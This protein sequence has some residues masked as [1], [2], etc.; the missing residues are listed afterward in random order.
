MA[1]HEA[2][3]VTIGRQRSP[4][5]ATGTSMVPYLRAANVKDGRLA[6]AD[7][8]EMNFTESEQATYDLH[9]GDVLVTE[10]CGSIRKIGASARWDGQIDGPVCFQNT[11]LR[12][13]AI[14]GLTLPGF[15]EQWA[16]WAHRSGLWATTASGTNIFHIGVQRAREVPIPVP[17]ID[18][19]RRIVDLVSGIERAIAGADE[20][21]T[22][23]AS[24]NE[25]IL[26]DWV[27]SWT[28]PTACLGDIATAGSGPSWK[29]ADETRTPVSGATRVLGITNTA[30]NAELDL[31][32]EKYV[33]G[34][35]ASTKKLSD[36]SVLMIRTNGNRSRIG[37]VYRVPAGA[38]GCAFSAFQIGLHFESPTD[39][40]FAFWMLAETEV[41][42]RVS[43]A[44]SGTTGLGNVGVRWLKQFK[45][46]W[47]ERTAERAELASLFDAG[48]A[49]AR[50]AAR[51]EDALSTVRTSVLS[52]LL[53]GE[54]AIPDRYDE[55]LEQ[56]S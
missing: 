48:S 14:P 56:A 35:P 52:E 42:N 45:L 40:E 11:L 32:E 26:S 22:A 18:V 38:V 49:A 43:N 19:Q 29:A 47:P 37:N 9:L 27:G 8:L 3:E 12:L 55:L 36:R 16:R 53:S 4:K 51:V 13:R 41:Q 25:R 44:A 6:L 10:G 20:S 54:H 24:L 21:A 33:V 1:L 39:A 5:N 7:V 17:P 15:V 2:A 30:A 28:G 50:S 46:P 34:L 31:S 23:H